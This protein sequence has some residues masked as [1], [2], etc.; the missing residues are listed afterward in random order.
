MDY[1]DK[2]L[3][4]LGIN[5]CAF[6]R[7]KTFAKEHFSDEIDNII[8]HCPLGAKLNV[9]W[10]KNPYKEEKEDIN[11]TISKKKKLLW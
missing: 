11:V 4:N 2:P 7:I 6:E 8:Q 1:F 5:Y 3:N 10:L 9:L